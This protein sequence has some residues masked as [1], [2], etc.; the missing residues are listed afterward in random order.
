MFSAAQTI[1]LVRLLAEMLG[2]A[3]GYPKLL[4]VCAGGDVESLAFENWNA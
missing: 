1:P 3:P 4:P 2:V